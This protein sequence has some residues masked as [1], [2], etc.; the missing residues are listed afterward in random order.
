M[1]ESGSS[2]AL[3]LR[4]CR[5]PFT[6]RLRI[7]RLGSSTAIDA[8]RTRAELSSAGDEGRDENKPLTLCTRELGRDRFGASSVRDGDG[9]VKF[10]GI[11]DLEVARGL[12]NGEAE[13]GD[14]D[15]EALPMGPS[16]SV[17]V[18]LDFFERRRGLTPLLLK[19]VL[20]TLCERSDRITGLRG[21]RILSCFFRRPFDIVNAE[22]DREADR[23]EIL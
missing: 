4:R 8:T 6:Q 20:L 1:P 18:I 2:G 10:D 5:V 11:C 21:T 22:L 13:E 3:W 12:W 14:T 17:D 7:E 16:D 9:K 15:S 19:D 23:F